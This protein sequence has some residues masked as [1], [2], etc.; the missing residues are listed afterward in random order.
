MMLLY[1][2]RMIGNKAAV[3]T[4][5]AGLDRYIRSLPCG[6]YPIT[7]ITQASNMPLTTREWGVAVHHEDGTVQ[8]RPTLS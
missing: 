6:H 2:V 5:P 7:E 3:A 1:Q 4:T 8:I